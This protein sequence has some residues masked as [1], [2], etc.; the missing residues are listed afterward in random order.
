MSITE[1][2]A[3]A[4]ATTMDVM[5]AIRGRRSVGKVRQVLPSRK[6]IETILEAATWAPCHHVTEPWR[7][8]VIAGEAREA[9]GEVMALF[10]GEYIHVGGDEA[11]KPQ[12]EASPRV[13]ARMKQFGVKDAHDLQ[14]YFIQR[15]GKFIDSKGRKLIGWDEILEGGLA[16]NATVMSMPIAFGG[17][18]LASGRRATSSSTKRRSTRARRAPFPRL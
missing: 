12:W 7:F 10:P 9:L 15:M 17:R 13:K 2:D 8:R 11:V 16:P 3:P 6:A 4:T 14:G 5:D 1:L 18:H